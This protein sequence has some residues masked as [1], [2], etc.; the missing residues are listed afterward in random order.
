MKTEDAFKKNVG[1]FLAL[2]TMP[3]FQRWDNTPT[4]MLTHAVFKIQTDSTKGHPSCST[5]GRAESL[6]QRQYPGPHFPSASFRAR[7][8]DSQ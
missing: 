7:D 2:C 5:K 6:C 8:A 3:I 4:K 1:C